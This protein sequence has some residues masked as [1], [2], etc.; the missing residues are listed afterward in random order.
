MHVFILLFLNFNIVIIVIHLIIFIILIR[1]AIWIVDDII[2]VNIMIM[3]LFLIL[4]IHHIFS[5]TDSLV[6]FPSASSALISFSLL[7]WLQLLFNATVEPNQQITAPVFGWTGV[8]GVVFL[9]HS[10]LRG[11]LEHVAVGVVVAECDLEMDEW[12]R[13]LTVPE[14]YWVEDGT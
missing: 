11:V 10:P 8:V 5:A 6:I 4:F 2:H 3:I 14:E 13:D 7:N 1:V 9:R 12:Y